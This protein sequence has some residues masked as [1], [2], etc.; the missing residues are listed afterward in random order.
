MEAIWGAR[1]IFNDFLMILTAIWGAI[2][3]TILDIGGHL[4]RFG[5]TNGRHFGSDVFLMLLLTS[6]GEANVPPVQ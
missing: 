3:D 4:W 1:W 6:G 2:F 5:A